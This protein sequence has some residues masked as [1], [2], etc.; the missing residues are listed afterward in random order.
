M[1][2]EIDEGQITL[3][4]VHAEPWLHPVEPVRV[5]RGLGR[6]AEILVEHLRVLND[7]AWNARAVAM[8]PDR[9]SDTPTWFWED[10]F[11]DL[12]VLRIR[13]LDDAA[14]VG[15]ILEGPVLA[16]GVA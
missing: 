1:R 2:V 12:A 16:P 4:F 10:W 13:G 5:E 7:T 6:V 3:Y 11:F 9:L 14:I 15:R 8:R